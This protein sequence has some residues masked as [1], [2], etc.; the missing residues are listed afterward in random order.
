MGA[1]VQAFEAYAVAHEHDVVVL[2]GECPT[3]QVLQL[4]FLVRNADH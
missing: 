1:G 2:G 4:I 3:V